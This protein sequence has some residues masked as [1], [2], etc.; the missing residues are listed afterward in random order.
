MLRENALLVKKVWNKI[1]DAK[2][3]K[4]KLNVGTP[5]KK[6]KFIY[7]EVKWLKKL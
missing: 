5:I 2:R 6:V 3:K 1:V 4:G 7:K